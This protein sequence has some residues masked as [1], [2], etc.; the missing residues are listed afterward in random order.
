MVRKELLQIL[1]CP[2]DGEPLVQAEV[3]LVNALNEAIRAGSVTN[4]AG[5]LVDEPLEQ[6]LVREDGA[7]LYA[8][9]DDIPKMLA[10]EAIPVGN[11]F[12]KHQREPSR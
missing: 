5:Q 3:E 1:R 4:R 12:E 9:E 8:I 2:I 7:W 6:G 11:L 10:D